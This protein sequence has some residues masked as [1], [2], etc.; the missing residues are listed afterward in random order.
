M[1]LSKP[2]TFVLIFAFFFGCFFALYDKLNEEKAGIETVVVQSNDTLWEIAERLGTYKD[3]RYTVQE[4]K[5]LN[6]LRDS[7]IYPGQELLV[8]R[9]SRQLVGMEMDFLVE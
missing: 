4:I 1:G 5:K 3:I 2:V 9:T 7:T 6:G 8:P